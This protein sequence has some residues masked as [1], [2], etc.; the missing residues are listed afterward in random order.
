L[1][2]REPQKVEIVRVGEDTSALLKQLSILLENMNRFFELSLTPAGRLKV[3]NIPVAIGD[4]KE[5]QENLVSSVIRIPALLEQLTL[6]VKQTR[7]MLSQLIT[8]DAS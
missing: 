1:G 5:S 3:A 6:E 8:K 4:T 2:D 7:E